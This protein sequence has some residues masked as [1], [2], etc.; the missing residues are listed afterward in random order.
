M[1]GRD[2]WNA[3]RW[4][5][6]EWKS[7]ELQIRRDKRESIANRFVFHFIIIFAGPDARP[8]HPA[9][10]E[11][12]SHLRVC[13]TAH[14]SA[15]ICAHPPADQ[16]LAFTSNKSVARHVLLFHTQSSPNKADDDNNSWSA[17]LWMKH[18]VG[19]ATCVCPPVCMCGCACY[20]SSSI[21]IRYSC[22]AFN[23]DYTPIKGPSSPACHPHG[24]QIAF[25]NREEIYLLCS[26]RQLKWMWH[27]WDWV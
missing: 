9:R 14:T 24:C 16:S 5:S 10:R 18:P 7:N 15:Y 17:K 25:I 2:T 1:R 6:A 8:G 12:V 27:R 19:L 26:L 3:S 11:S 22:W 20:V 21:W 13:V 4:T 23:N